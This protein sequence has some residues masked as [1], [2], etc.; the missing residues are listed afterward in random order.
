MNFLVRITLKM[1]R[2]LRECKNELQLSLEKGIIDYCVKTHSCSGHEGV[3]FSFV[4]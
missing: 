1:N 4:V 2:N 3:W